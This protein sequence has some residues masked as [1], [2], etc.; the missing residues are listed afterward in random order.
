[1]DYP[2]V[3]IKVWGA[4]ANFTRPEAKVERVSYEVMTPSAARNIL[5][6]IYWHPQMQWQ[7]REIWVLSPIRWTSFISNEL[8]GRAT[9]QYARARTAAQGQS[10][11]MQYGRQ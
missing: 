11:T 1:M 6:S 4:L 8:E 5:Q 2:P 9:M 7:I 3:T 10:Y